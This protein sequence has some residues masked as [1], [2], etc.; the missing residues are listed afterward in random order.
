MIS[1]SEL[2]RLNPEQ[3]R[4]ALADYLNAR[5]PIPIIGEPTPAQRVARDAMHIWDAVLRNTARPLLRALKHPSD[6]QPAA[7]QQ[8]LVDAFV[9]R[10]SKLSREE[11]CNLVSVMHAEELE[12][13]VAQ[14][15]AA[16]HVGE[17]MD[18]RD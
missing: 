3:R 13:Q 6:Y 15:V 11:L 5:S 12:K 14:M 7:T 9:S 1:D 4:L 16:G 2:N 17:D 8:L 10:F 18:K